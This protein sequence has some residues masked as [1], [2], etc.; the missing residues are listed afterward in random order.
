MPLSRRELIAFALTA[1]W[2][3]HLSA[4]GRQKVAA[5][6]DFVWLD[7]TTIAARVAA[8]TLSIVELTDAYLQRI[9]RL[10]PSLTAYVTVTAERARD[11]ARR[12]EAQIRQGQP[13]G[14]LAGIPIAHKDL[15]ETAGIR[16]TA[17]SRL[18]ETHTPKAD[19]TIVDET[20]GG[21]HGPAGQEQHPRARRRRHD[22]QS[23]L[24]HDAQSLGSHAHRRRI[25][26][27]IG[28]GRRGR[29]GRGRHRQRYRWQRPHP[30]R[31]LRVRRLQAD[32]R[33]HQHGR[34]ARRGADVRSRRPHHAD[35]CRPRGDL[36]GDGGL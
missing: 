29:P 6:D 32:L 23:V 4:R 17:G 8:R 1:A 10:N 3:Q 24:R 33:P 13:P 35:G 9:E 11:D 5:Q 26:R 16:T 18:Y 22:D 14:R 30:G 31:L 25:E 19:A 7:A 21:R 20:R 2:S 34:P 36:S 27:R 28:G 12:I 15:F